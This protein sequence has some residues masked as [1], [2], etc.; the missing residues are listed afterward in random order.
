M[1]C[2]L[3]SHFL[4]LAISLV[5]ILFVCSICAYTGNSEAK[6][7]QLP[8]VYELVVADGKTVLKPYPQM[9]QSESETFILN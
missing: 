5:I 7:D 9:Q 6:S 4:K 1:T 2:N 8:T 3:K